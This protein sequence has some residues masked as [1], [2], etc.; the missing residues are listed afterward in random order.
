MSKISDLKA[1]YDR[2]EKRENKI[3]EINDIVQKKGEILRFSFSCWLIVAVL[4]LLIDFFV[5]LFNTLVFEI[6]DPAKIIVIIIGLLSIAP[7]VLVLNYV[8]GILKAELKIKKINEDDKLRKSD[9]SISNEDVDLLLKGLENM[10][11]EEVDD[12][13]SFIVEEIIEKK[14]IK[15]EKTIN[16]NSNKLKKASMREITKKLNLEIENI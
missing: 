9:L 11:D 16:S 12:I 3:K 10:T 1:A 15:E 8:F 6:G 4:F 14:K 7:T 2:I 13:P 5:L